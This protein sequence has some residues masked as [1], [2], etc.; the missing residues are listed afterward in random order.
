M[1]PRN[2]KTC[3]YKLILVGLL[4][5]TIGCGGRS[6][7]A[8]ISTSK[9]TLDK[10]LRDKQLRVAY[11]QYPPTAFRDPG[12]GEMRGHFVDALRE[13]LNQLQ[14]NIKIEFEETNWADFTSALESGRVD[15]S[16]AGTFASI[17][18]AKRVAF[19][20]PLVYLGRSA[21]IRRDDHRFSPERGLGQ[22]DAPGI[23][24]GVVDG[25]GAH[26]YVKSHFRNLQG[27]VVFSGS[28]LSQS[29]A[30]VSSGQVDVGLSDAM[31]TSKYAKAHP[32]VVDLFAD[33]PFGIQPIGWAV[34]HDDI[35]W[36]NF[37]DTALE[38]LETQGRLLEFEQRYDYRWLHPVMRFSRQ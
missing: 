3:W 22:F 14:P 19:T 25:E 7:D 21:T 20:R 28:E 33:R 5:L 30:A 9:G 15:L 1:R 17:P 29:L 2:Q 11:I 12:S 37:L 38:T 13:I 36:K 35:I 34:R 26:E 10:V 23:R 16:I 27:L 31:E 32:E 4:S 6:L 18:R 24:I 8:K